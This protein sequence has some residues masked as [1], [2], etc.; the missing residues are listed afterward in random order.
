MVIEHDITC[1]NNAAYFESSRGQLSSIKIT[2]LKHKHVCKLNFTILFS[3]CV[4]V[5]G[6]CLRM[7]F[8][9]QLLHYDSFYS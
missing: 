8:C 3:V 5:S 7:S 6:E 2:Y 9:Y 1:I 4:A